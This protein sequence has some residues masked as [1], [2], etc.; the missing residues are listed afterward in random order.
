LPNI[1]KAVE[2]QLGLRLVKINGIP[3]DAIVVDHIE[4]VPIEN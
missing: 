3:L 4:K 1:F 2:Q